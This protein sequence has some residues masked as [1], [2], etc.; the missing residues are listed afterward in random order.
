[1]RKEK[2]GV[3]VMYAHGDAFFRVELFRAVIMG[4]RLHIR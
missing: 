3:S 1:M 4:Q 2:R